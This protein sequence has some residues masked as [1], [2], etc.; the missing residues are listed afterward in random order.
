MSFNAICE[1]KIL[2]KISESTVWFSWTGSEVGVR[3]LLVFG[4]I[5]FEP[6]KLGKLDAI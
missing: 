6:S 4:K 5:A 2:A 1:N 3:A